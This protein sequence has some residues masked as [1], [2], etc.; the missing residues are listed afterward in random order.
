VETDLARGLPEDGIKSPSLHTST[1]ID[2]VTAMILEGNG[3]T[4]LTLNDPFWEK[5]CRSLEMKTLI[6]GEDVVYSS[7][8]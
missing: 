3:I 6:E 8:E 5:F 7:A 4:H 1:R 2:A